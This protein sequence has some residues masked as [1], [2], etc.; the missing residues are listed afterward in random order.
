MKALL[1]GGTGTISSAITHLVAGDKAHTVIF[2]NSK[3]K[4]AVPG[5]CATTRFDQGA[6]LSIDYM[7]SHP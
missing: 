6:K 5:F 1:I 7:M 4:R 2:D 3:V